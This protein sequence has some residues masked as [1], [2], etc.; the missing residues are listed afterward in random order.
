MELK[1]FFPYS[2]EATDLLRRSDRIQGDLQHCLDISE[3]MNL[4]IREFV[5]FPVKNEFRGFVYKEKF[6]ALTQYNNLAYFPEHLEIKSEIE[7]KMKEFIEGMKYVMECFI[8]DLVIDD[9]GKVWVVEINPFGE[10]AGA[11]LFSWS[12]DRDVLMGKKPF[13]F[14]IVEEKPTLQYIK[15]EIDPKVFELIKIE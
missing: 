15:S 2:Q 1:F 3:P 7:Q 4:I 6:T 8:L 10:L 11:C 13:E 14:R 5:S 12:K 9:K